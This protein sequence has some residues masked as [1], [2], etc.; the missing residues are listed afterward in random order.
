[1]KLSGTFCTDHNDAGG[2][3]MYDRENKTWNWKIVDYIGLDHD[4]LPDVYPSDKVV[5]AVSE[6]A[7][8]ETGLVAGIPD[9]APTTLSDG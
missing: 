9:T 4:K 3:A 2:S 7:A 6:K 8:K 1:M 5:G